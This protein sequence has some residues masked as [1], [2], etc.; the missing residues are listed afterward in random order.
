M[1]RK[2]KLFLSSD[3]LFFF[4]FPRPFP[5]PNQFQPQLEITLLLLWWGTMKNAAH[6]FRES[7]SEPKILHKTAPLFRLNPPFCIN[8]RQ[9]SAQCAKRFISKCS[10]M[11][12]HLQLPLIKTKGGTQALCKPSTTLSI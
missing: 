12:C 7:R 5:I 3:F 1:L 10:S 8:N 4:P 9:S 2:S 6:Y 11:L